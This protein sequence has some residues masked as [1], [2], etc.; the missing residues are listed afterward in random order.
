M[1]KL[2]SILLRV[3]SLNIEVSCF[4]IKV[5]CLKISSVYMFRA[6]SFLIVVIRAFQCGLVLKG[7]IKSKPLCFAINAQ[8]LIFVHCK[9]SLVSAHT[10]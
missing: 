7:A 9:S 10:M 6:L 2:S 4:K 3:F 1:L 8:T 5:A